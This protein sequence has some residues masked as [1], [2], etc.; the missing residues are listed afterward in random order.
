MIIFEKRLQRTKFEVKTKISI[1]SNRKYGEVT[2]N[3][4]FIQFNN[5][6]STTATQYNVM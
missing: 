1:H 6:H 2:V 4:Y 5:R 3:L